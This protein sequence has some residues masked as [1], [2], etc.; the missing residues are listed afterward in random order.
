MKNYYVVEDGG[1]IQLKMIKRSVHLSV[2]LVV[3][4]GNGHIGEAK[5]KLCPPRFFTNSRVYLGGTE[6]II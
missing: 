4:L 3:H 1:S 2:G 5:Q 6:E